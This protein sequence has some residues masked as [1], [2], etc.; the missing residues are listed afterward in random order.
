MADQ[1]PATSL[2]ARRLVAS[3]PQYAQAQQAVD[4]LADQKFPVERVA[5]VGEGLRLVEQVTGRRTWGSVILEGLLGGLITGLLLG[6]LFGLL[7]LINPLVSS[8]T[9]ALWG[10]VLGAV[11]GGIA[12]VIG[13]AATGGRRDFT[14]VGMM[15][16]DHYN[17][18]VDAD[19]A[20]EAQRLIARMPA[21]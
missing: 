19:V 8:L 17:V 5:I 7:N 3:F 13:Y 4:Y 9:L 1:F 11:I 18:L 12:G 10:L 15:Q 21:R 2:P 14:S 6:W 20:E 16:A